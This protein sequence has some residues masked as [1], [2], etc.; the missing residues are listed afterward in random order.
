MNEREDQGKGLQDSGK[1]APILMS[2]QLW[3]SKGSV[4]NPHVFR[5]V[6][7]SPW[8]HSLCSS[9]ISDYY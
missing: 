3:T 9:F 4:V 7:A 6:I 2:N 5:V 1:G 8:R